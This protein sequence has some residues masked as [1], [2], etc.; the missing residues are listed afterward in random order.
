M[1]ITNRNNMKLQKE[2][3]A[4]FGTETVRTI[5]Q[6]ISGHDFGMFRRFLNP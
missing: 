6:N 1:I 5:V 3:L 4:T 2:E